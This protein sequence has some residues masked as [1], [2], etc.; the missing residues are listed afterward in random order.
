MADFK[1]LYEGKMR[2]E[3]RI[4]KARKELAESEVRLKTVN[5]EIEADTLAMA[6]R[7]KERQAWFDQGRS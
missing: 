1:Q 6:E 7:S 4:V 5:Q 2:L 3:K